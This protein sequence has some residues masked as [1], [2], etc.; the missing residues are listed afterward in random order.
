MLYF[1]TSGRLSLLRRALQAL[2]NLVLTLFCML[3]GIVHAILV[4]NSH[5]ADPRNKQLIQHYDADSSHV[6]KMEVLVDA[7]SLTDI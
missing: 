7:D 5:L 3:P 2:L 6:G 1:A 4:V